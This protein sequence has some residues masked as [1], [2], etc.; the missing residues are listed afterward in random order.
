MKDMD[1]NEY[2]IES[3]KTV[4]YPAPGN[5]IIYPTLGLAAEAGEV[6]NKVKKVLRDNRGQF[7][8]THKREIVAEVGDVLWYCAQIATE[9]GLSLDDVA[10]ENIKKLSSR[11][12]RGVLGGN[13]D[14]R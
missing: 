11:M 2:Q 5:N 13:G 8:D 7:G 10:A 4:V 6:A 12:D 14:A 1:F 9:L 3:R